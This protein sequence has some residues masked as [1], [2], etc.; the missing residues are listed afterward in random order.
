MGD[1]MSWREQYPFESNYWESQYGKIHYLDEGPKVGQ[2]GGEVPVVVMVH[3]NPTWSFFYRNVVALL[4]DRV[5][6]IVPDHLG[7]GLSDKPQ[8][9]P[10]TLATHIRNLQGLLASLG[11]QKA[12]LIVHDWGGPIGVGSFLLDETS[13]TVQGAQAPVLEKLAVLNTAPGYSADVPKRILLCRA[14]VVGELLV[15]GFNGFAWPATWMSVEK[16]LSKETKE[17]FLYPYG[18]W[19]DRIATHRF[20]RDIPRSSQDPAWAVL[21]EIEE[22]LPKLGQVPAAIYWGLKDFCFHKGYYQAWCKALPHA[23]RHPYEQAGHY[24]LEDAGNQ[25]LPLLEKQFV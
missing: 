15:R 21:H 24:L 7:C 20:V 10:Y 2:D 17:G 25:I 23:Q 14:P 3:G 12:S 1:A 16:P 18:N 8:Q 22:R 19:R 5:R 4:R 9:A 6:C 11:I 13:R